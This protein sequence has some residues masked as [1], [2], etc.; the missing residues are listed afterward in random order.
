[1]APTLSRTLAALA[2][3]AAILLPSVPGSGAEKK[4]SSLSEDIR[5]GVKE[6]KEDVKK[7]GPVI[8]KTAVKVGKDVKKGFG[9]V[10]EGLKDTGKRI[11][12]DK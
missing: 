6:V 1:M 12:E 5:H 3:T 11:K 4:K 2:V 9:E 8:K 10:K 7:S